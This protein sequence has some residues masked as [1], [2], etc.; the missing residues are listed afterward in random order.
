MARPFSPGLPAVER[1]RCSFT[2]KILF[3][4]YGTATYQGAPQVRTAADPV[5]R[6]CVLL[7][8]LILPFSLL[9]PFPPLLLII[10]VLLPFI[11]LIVFQ[12]GLRRLHKLRLLGCGLRLRGGRRRL[13][14]ARE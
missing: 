10:V 7:L 14:D 1:K 9:F 3:C 4:P 6:S 11:I 8:A 5:R 2:K 12:L 13:R